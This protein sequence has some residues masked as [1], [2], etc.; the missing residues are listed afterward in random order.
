M[1]SA[2]WPVNNCINSRGGHIF[3]CR[4][5]RSLKRAADGVVGILRLG[6][7]KISVFRTRKSDFRFS[8]ASAP[9]LLLSQ[10]SKRIGS[11]ARCFRVV[12]LGD[13]PLLLHRLFLG[14]DEASYVT[15]QTIFACGGL[16][17]YPEFRI[18]WSSG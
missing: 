4:E 13:F 17:L 6:S 15:G 16:T 2:C 14:S 5:Q 10:A 9:A 8:S 11:L 3:N 1:C 12:A 18:A 7:Y